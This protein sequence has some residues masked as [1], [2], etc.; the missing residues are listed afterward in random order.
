MADQKAIEEALKNAR[1]DLTVLSTKLTTV[2]FTS[3]DVKAL[4]E[5]IKQHDEL[6]ED[7]EVATAKERMEA[8]AVMMDLCSGND[9]AL[10]KALTIKGLSA[11]QA[12]HLRDIEAMPELMQFDQNSSSLEDLKNDLNEHRKANA[13]ASAD[14]QAKIAQFD[15]MCARLNSLTCNLQQLDEIMTFAKDNGFEGDNR[16]KQA[17][18]LKLCILWLNNKNSAGATL[19]A[20]SKMIMGYIDN[21]ITNNWVPSSSIDFLR[22]VK[23]NQSA[24][25]SLPIDKKVCN[26]L[27]QVKQAIEAQI[28]EEL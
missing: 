7:E 10:A 11:E 12:K 22:K 17:E 19:Y 4:D 28:G 18:K 3:S 15:K 24:V 16:Y 20:D 27:S 23:A 14:Q 21:Y 25:A 5:F 2:D 8:A 1:K 13:E 6:Q 26:S 9:E